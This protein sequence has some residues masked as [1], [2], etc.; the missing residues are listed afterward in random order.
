MGGKLDYVVVWV[1][2]LN[3]NFV[4]VFCACRPLQRDA[5]EHLIKCALM[6]GGFGPLGGG[7]VNLE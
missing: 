7:T 4:S 1:I 2:K 5:N 3:D 6:V